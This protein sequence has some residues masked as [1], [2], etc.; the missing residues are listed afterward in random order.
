[1]ELDN[2]TENQT[3]LLKHIVD[4]LGGPTATYTLLKTIE[5][6]LGE[7]K[8]DYVHDPQAMSDELREKVDVCIAALNY[9][10]IKQLSD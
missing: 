6:L 4:D 1:M 3:E 8:P 2:F 9:Q 10:K 7:L 5:D